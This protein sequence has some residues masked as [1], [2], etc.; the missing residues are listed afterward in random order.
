MKTVVAQNH[1]LHFKF[2]GPLMSTEVLLELL[3][4]QTFRMDGCSHERKW[5]VACTTA[6]T[7]AA[8]PAATLSTSAA[9]RGAGRPCGMQE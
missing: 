9:P 6:A 2:L 3:L 4:G 8:C 7:A 1:E 5:S